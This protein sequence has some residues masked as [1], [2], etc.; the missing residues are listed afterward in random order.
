MR[1]YVTIFF[2]ITADHADQMRMQWLEF[3]TTNAKCWLCE[4]FQCDCNDI[5]TAHAIE[6]ATNRSHHGGQCEARAHV[7]VE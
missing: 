3:R 4:T 7:C 6:Y 2:A 1:A 5:S